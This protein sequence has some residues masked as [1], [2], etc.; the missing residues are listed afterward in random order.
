LESE[1]PTGADQQDRTVDELSSRL[2]DGLKC[3]HSVVSNYRVLLGSA[4]APLQAEND[5]LGDALMSA[6]CASENR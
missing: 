3:C 6:D 2:S 1:V 5:Q 4:G